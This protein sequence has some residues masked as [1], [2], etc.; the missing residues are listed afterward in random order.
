MRKQIRMYVTAPE[1]CTEDQFEEWVEFSLGIRG[2]CQLTNPLADYSL[3]A[4]D[5]D[6]YD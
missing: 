6:I 3:E 2:D 5:V 1:E 4:E